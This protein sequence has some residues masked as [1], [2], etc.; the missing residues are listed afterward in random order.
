M[1]EQILSNILNLPGSN[2]ADLLGGSD[3]VAPDVSALTGDPETLLFRI[4]GQGDQVLGAVGQ[5]IPDDVKAVFTDPDDPDGDELTDAWDIPELVPANHS[6]P[7]GLVQD[8]TQNAVTDAADNALA[9]ALADA[10]GLAS[11]AGLGG[12]AADATDF[13]HALGLDA[14][15][16]SGTVGGA[17]GVASDLI[18][19][20]NADVDHLISD[21]DLAAVAA[22]DLVNGL[23]SDLPGELLGSGGIVPNALADVESALGNAGGA[24][25]GLLSPLQQGPILDAAVL[26]NAFPG[27]DGLLHA[28]VDASP[29]SNGLI[30]LDVIGQPHGSS[31]LI[32]ADALPVSN[33]SIAHL[34]FLTSPESGPQSPITADV[35]N[36]PNLVN[37]QLLTS[38]NALGG[39]GA[40]AGADHL[41]V[42]Q[43]AGAGADS[44]VGA[45]A[46]DAVSPIGIAAAAHE[47]GPVVDAA[48]H[49]AAD[50]MVAP[51][52]HVNVMADAQAVVDHAA[53][54]LI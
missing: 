42:P 15:G 49:L 23:G 52:Q 33:E 32:E 6:I 2:F 53:H 31:H 25:D 22:H 4:E 19:Q 29:G 7:S 5:V 14:I 40:L 50:A 21:F 20:V 38:A 24:L 36:G 48:A 51:D 9:G 18:D 47:A 34:S 54:A 1:A 26:P 39:E 30:S 41:I 46:H 3:V 28:V 27:S 35:G 8:A 43:Q 37:A 17:G 44:L 10:S 12:T 13:A 16:H 45:L 11:G